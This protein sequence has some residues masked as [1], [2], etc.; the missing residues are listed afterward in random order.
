MQVL[1]KLPKVPSDLDVR[2]NE[3]QWGGVVQIL[4]SAATN[5]VLSKVYTRQNDKLSA[6]KRTKKKKKNE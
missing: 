1:L 5:T 2:D 4:L 6:D 3:H